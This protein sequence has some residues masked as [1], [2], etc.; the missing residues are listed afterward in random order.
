MKFPACHGWWHQRAKNNL[1]PM[2]YPYDDRSVPIK[3]P[4]S[5]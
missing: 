3:S 4:P 2:K 5:W 1:I